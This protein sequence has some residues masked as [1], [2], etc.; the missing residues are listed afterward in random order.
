LALKN[1]SLLSRY[2]TKGKA[3][4]EHDMHTNRVRRQMLKASAGLAALGA[5][6]LSGNVMAGVIGKAVPPAATAAYLGYWQGGRGLNNFRDVR[7]ASMGSCASAPH[8][9]ACALDDT[10]IDAAS[11]A[12]AKTANWY[13]SL[14]VIGFDGGG[15]S[16]SSL[17]LEPIYALGGNQL[18]RWRAGVV[19][20]SPVSCTWSA[21]RGDPLAVRVTA[22]DERGATQ[23]Q[24][25]SIPALPGVYVLALNTPGASAIS[26][27]RYSLQASSKDT[28]LTLALSQR[29]SGGFASGLSYVLIAVDKL[30]A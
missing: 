21:G 22:R 11:V 4:N 14:R 28:P 1:L 6:G 29:G 23:I 19:A 13:G 16:W 17:S 27:Q 2:A 3:M 18:W 10:V 9:V 8:T 25:I 30:S 5:C 15:A 24:Q 26:W 7:A 20:S 12:G